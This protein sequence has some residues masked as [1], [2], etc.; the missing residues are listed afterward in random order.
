MATPCAVAGGSIRDLLVTG[1]YQAS[2]MAAK[3]TATA[4]IGERGAQRHPGP[5]AAGLDGPFRDAQQDG[6]LRAG[7]AVQHGRLDGAA[8]FRGQL[9]QSLTQ[10]AV[11]DT[12]QHLILSGDNYRWFRRTPRQP[13]PGPVLPANHVD[14]TADAYSPDERRDVAVPPVGAGFPPQG[15]EGV[16]DRVVDHIRRR[17]P[18]R[19]PDGQPARVPVIRSGKSLLITACQTAQQCRV[20][21]LL[22]TRPH[23][24]SRSRAPMQSLS[25]QQAS[26]VPIIQDQISWGSGPHRHRGSVI[27]LG[28]RTSQSGPR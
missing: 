26:S 11:L 15:K 18:P 21:A 13:P 23:S 8:Q 10:T 14:Q 2:A 12:D 24:R 19:H 6:R 28:T 7:Q 5:V 9:G 20:I 25:H 17:A 3:L 1:A 16:L 22:G 4:M 27:P